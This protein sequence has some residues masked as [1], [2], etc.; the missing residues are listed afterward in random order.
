LVP[1]CASEADP[2]S[3]LAIAFNVPARA[4][5]FPAN[6]FIAALIEDSVSS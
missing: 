2:E 1:G 6:F 4:Y 3:Q 5:N